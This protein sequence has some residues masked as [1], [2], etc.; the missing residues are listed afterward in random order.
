MD[1]SLTSPARARVFVL[2]AALLWSTSG[3]FTKV[4]TQDTAFGL[5]EPPLE[6]F[7]FAGLAF[8]V[9]I[10][11]YRVLFAGLVLTPTLRRQDIRFRPLMIVMALCFASMNVL[12]ISAMALGPAANAIYLQY[13]APLWM[14]L[15]GVFWL[16][17][18]ADRR[19]LITLFVGLAGI[20]IIV[21]GGGLNQ[22]LPITLLAL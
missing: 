3:A 2:I 21:A 12:F 5:N 4:L 11:C 6:S 17:E 10:A 22:G 15:V 1:A 18:T 9:Q 14:F 16:G 7:H 19:G 13:S 8:P 20:G